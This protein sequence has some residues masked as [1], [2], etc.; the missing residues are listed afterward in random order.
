MKKVALLII[1]I[2]FLSGCGRVNGLI[3]DEKDVVNKSV[4]GVDM[5]NYSKIN[6]D[7]INSIHDESSDNIIDFV[8]NFVNENS[9]HLIDDEHERYAWDSK[10]VHKMIYQYY[11]GKSE[12][13]PHLS[14]GPR[15]KIMREILTNMGIKSRNVI[16]FSDNYDNIRS[17]T[18]LEVFNSSRGVWEAHDPDFNISYIDINTGKNV[19]VIDLVFGDIDSIKPKNKKGIGWNIDYGK[20]GLA[21]LKYKFFDAVLYKESSIMVV[22]KHKFDVD[23]NF[24]INNMTF[25]D[26]SFKHYNQVIKKLRYFELNDIDQD[27]LDLIGKGE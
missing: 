4:N 20:M 14:C 13:K 19:S 26:F 15:A 16:T 12:K 24:K 17:H 7:Y 8:R 5:N 3:T 6:S 1:G 23:K 27:L 9:I 22:N 21:N 18:Y 11:S 10:I 2:F 25:K